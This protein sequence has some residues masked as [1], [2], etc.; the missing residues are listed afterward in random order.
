MAYDSNAETIMVQVALP[1]C[2]HL[3]QLQQRLPLALRHPQLP[4]LPLIMSTH[5]TVLRATS[6]DLSIDAMWCNTALYV[7]CG[8]LAGRATCTMMVSALL[9]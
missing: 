4:K 5:Q 3:R 8:T 6:L 2:H 9:S 1:R 7:K